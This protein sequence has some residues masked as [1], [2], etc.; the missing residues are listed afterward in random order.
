MSKQKKK[1]SL[2]LKINLVL[3]LVILV[4][5]LIGIFSPLALPFICIYLVFKEIMRSIESKRKTKFL[6]WYVTKNERK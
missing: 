6:K 1:I 3:F 2:R 5:I 4:L